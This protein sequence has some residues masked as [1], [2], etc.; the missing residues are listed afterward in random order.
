MKN[1]KEIKKY[2]EIKKMVDNPNVWYKGMEKNDVMVNM[3]DGN[4]L[5]QKKNVKNIEILYKNI[6]KLYKKRVDS[7][8]IMKES[9]EEKVKIF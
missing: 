2:G 4:D 9:F 7:K 1:K 6:D 8:N 3:I 5:N